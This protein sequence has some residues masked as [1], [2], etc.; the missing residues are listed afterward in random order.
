MGGE[1]NSL[2]KLM[3]KPK[4]NRHYLTIGLR[5]YSDN[6]RHNAIIECIVECQPHATFQ[7]IFTFC[8]NKYRE[9][10]DMDARL[11]LFSDLHDL[12]ESGKLFKE[13]KN[14]EERG[15]YKPHYYTNIKE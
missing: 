3:R 13:W 10:G 8:R 9:N 11:D 5:K 12:V 7:T 4:S 6:E 14:C 2:M 15:K 1:V